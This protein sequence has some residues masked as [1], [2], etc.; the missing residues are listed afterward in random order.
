MYQA[1]GI[2]YIHQGAESPP[3]SVLED[4]VAQGKAQFEKTLFYTTWRSLEH[5]TGC[6]QHLAVRRKMFLSEN[7]HC[8][9][10]Q[11]G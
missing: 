2:V 11:S 8:P 3:Y 5:G 7:N 6:S 9:R 1:D 4:G 10:P